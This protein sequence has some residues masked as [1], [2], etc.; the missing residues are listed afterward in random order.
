MIIKYCLSI[1][2]KSPGAYE[3]LRLNEK[4]GT[5]ILVLPSQRTLRDYRNYIRPQRGFNAMIINELREK[6][7]V[8][9]E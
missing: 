4:K 9:A 6:T 3:E 7:K 8:F 5:G 1:A 2:A